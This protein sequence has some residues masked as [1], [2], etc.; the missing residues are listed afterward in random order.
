MRKEKVLTIDSTA[1]LTKNGSHAIRRALREGKIH[2]NYVL[3]IGGQKIV[4]LPLDLVHSYWFSSKGMDPFQRNLLA[5][6]RS[7]I[8]HVTCKSYELE[9]LWG[10]IQC[11][12]STDDGIVKEEISKTSKQDEGGY[13]E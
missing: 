7:L 6:L 8:I 13:D 9:I 4:L 10:N 12:I 5:Q 2:R 1:S 11:F 3:D